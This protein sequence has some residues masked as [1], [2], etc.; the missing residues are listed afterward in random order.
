MIG[1]VLQGGGAKGGYHIGVWKALREMGIEIGGVTGTSVGALVGAFIAQGDYERA[2]DIWY[3]MDP[4][5]IF[6]DDPEIYHELVTGNYKI[7]NRHNYYDYFRKII[8]QNGLNIDPLVDLIEQEVDED[9]L[10][11]SEVDFGLVTVSL[12][13]WK[14]VEVFVE[15][16]EKGTVCDFLLASSFLP[17]FKPK[18]L[19]G[20]R[21]LDGGFYD[22]LPINL[23]SQ[24]G[25][26]EVVAVELQAPGVVRPV[27]NKDVNV[28][29][30]VPSGDIGSLMEFD[31]ERSRRN[32]QMGYLDT[33]QSYGKYHGFSYFLKDVPDET[34][35]YERL[36]RMTDSQIMDM[37][38]IIGEHRGIPRR[39]LNE[40]II[41]QLVEMLGM[42]MENGY[43][44]IMVGAVELMAASLKIERL[45]VY[46][47]EELSDIVMKT[48]KKD[49]QSLI[50]YDDMPDILKRRTLVRRNFKAD[51]LFRWQEIAAASFEP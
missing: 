39:L 35:F 46:S 17:G 43:R 14:A 3:N 27:R 50:N 7:K 48:K 49:T 21:Y 1:L 25:Y 33:M 15:D 29:R 20:K 22:N 36:L 9:R 11:V 38:A 19:H 37:A 26:S 47:Y 24:K 6:K 28:R 18:M 34:Y 31:T 42:S 10:R 5:L 2:Y 4:R 40:V 12:S 23:I 41:P 32:I 16:M 8:D 30:I 13:D 45:K 44:D 51:L